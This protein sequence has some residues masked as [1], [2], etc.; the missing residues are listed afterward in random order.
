MTVAS[1][2][3]AETIHNLVVKEEIHLKI[4]IKTIIDRIIITTAQIT[5]IA[6]IIHQII[7]T[8]VINELGVRNR[9]NE[10][11]S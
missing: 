11:K 4:T 9:S 7:T 8:I 6:T 3:L 5:A 2:I 1:T 10:S